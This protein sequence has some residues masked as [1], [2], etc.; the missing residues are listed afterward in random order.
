MATEID[1]LIVQISADTRQLKGELNKV[2]GQLDKTFPQG[3]RSPIAGFATQLK[4]L[5]GP[6]AGVASGMAAISVTRGIAQTGSQFEDLRDSLNTVFG[7]I[8]AGDK[9][10][11]RI[12]EFAQTTPFQI[13][14]ITKA[15][16]ALGAAGIEPTRDMLQ[17]FADTASTSVQQLEV[18]ETLVR[19]TQRSVSGGLNLEDLNQIMDK[20]IDVLGIL[21][22]E[23][24]LGK[25]DIA[26]FGA[27]AEGAQIIMAALMKGMKEKF[28]GA[29]AAKMDNLST[30]ASN[31]EIAFKS[32]QNVIFEGGLGDAL[33]NLTDR[34]TNF[35]NKVAE[36]MQKSR[37]LAAMQE[38]LPASVRT[39]L[40]REATEERTGRKVR[41]R[42]GQQVLSVEQAMEAERARLAER[43]LEIESQLTESTEGL[44]NR[45]IKALK[46]RQ[47]ALREEQTEIDASIQAMDNLALSRIKLSETPSPTGDD[48]G[49]GGGGPSM[50]QEQ[51]GLLARMQDILEDT[52]TPAEELAA[53]FADLQAIQDAGGLGLTEDQLGRIRTFLEG[54]QSDAALDEMKDKFGV[55]QSAVDGTVTPLEKLNEQIE[56]LEAAIAEGDADVLAFI[57]GNR[58]PEE[59]QAVIDRLKDNLKDLKTDTEETAASFAETMAPAIASMAHSFTNDFVNALMSGQNALQSFKDFAKNLVSQIIATFLQMAVVNQILNAIF[60]RFEG[61]TPLPTISFGGGQTGESASGGAMM[62]GK[63]YLVGERG[64][65]MFVPHTAGTLRNGNDTR[66]MMGGGR[67]IIVNQNLNF[68]TGVV[69]TVRAE[70]QRMLPAISEVTKVSVLE[71]TQRGGNYRRGLLGG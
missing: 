47:A 34:L 66:S 31:M 43:R 40:R 63:P 14:T 20:G 68:S 39:A 26:K 24:D 12:L 37:E 57:F 70:V 3:S 64:P 23:L 45:Q 58:T 54:I 4:G 25:D 15:F 71:A 55:L 38:G 48:G 9:Q 30:K 61:Y 11:E 53:Q 44:N 46:S 52:V 22:S 13:E 28:G 49:T 1:E 62:R 56:K 2:R 32:L 27:T 8:E 69:P 29:M 18:F 6:L 33:K 51:V 41:L 50:T 65:E 60:G 16:I 7:S 35:L 36:G 42:G 10:F 67:P 21:R 59:M 5:I 17:T 19:I